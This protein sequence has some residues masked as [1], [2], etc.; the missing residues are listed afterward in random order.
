MSA[1]GSYVYLV[2]TARAPANKY[3]QLDLTQLNAFNTALRN[4]R[5]KTNTTTSVGVYEKMRVIRFKMVP[6][7]SSY[8]VRTLLP[9]AHK[10]AI[11]L[12]KYGVSLG[13]SVRYTIPKRA[14][15]PIKFNWS[16]P[17]KLL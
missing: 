2:L 11:R 10:E 16:R 7:R 8:V 15:M 4:L 1:G 3:K 14:G 12:E 9:E 13:T 6:E 17:T 5:K